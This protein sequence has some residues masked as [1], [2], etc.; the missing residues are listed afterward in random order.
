MFDAGKKPKRGRLACENRNGLARPFRK[1]KASGGFSSRLW[2]IPTLREAHDG[3]PLD[4]GVV[5]QDYM[6]RPGAEV[7][8]YTRTSPRTRT[9]TSSHLAPPWAQSGPGPSAPICPSIHQNG[10][11]FVSRNAA[12]NRL[13]S[14]QV[15]RPSSTPAFGFE[16]WSQRQHRMS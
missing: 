10:S 1:G 12:P 13:C 11:P 6:K 9:H 3:S 4:D 16:S 7:C 14:M 2:G 5:G 15:K 8:I